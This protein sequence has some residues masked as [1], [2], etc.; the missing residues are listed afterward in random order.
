MSKL[1]LRR[2]PDMCFEPY[3]DSSM[4]FAFVIQLYDA[5]YKGHYEGQTDVID[6]SY[7]KGAIA[8][9]CSLRLNTDIVE[10]KIPVFFLVEDVL[11]SKIL[12]DLLNAGIKR[13]RIRC[14]TVPDSPV[15]KYRVS[16]G[17]YVIVDSVINQYGSYCKWDADLFA[18]CDPDIGQKLSTYWLQGD[19]IGVMEFHYNAVENVDSES[20]AHWF[21]KWDGS[22]DT[23]DYNFDRSRKSAEEAIGIDIL[24]DKGDRFSSMLCGIMRFPCIDK[25]PRDFLDF[26]FRLEPALGDEELILSLWVKYSNSWIRS[27]VPQPMCWWGDSVKDFRARGAY[28]L[29]CNSYLETEEDWESCFRTDIGASDSP[30][31][32]SLKDGGND[33]VP[34]VA[35]L[36]LERRVDRAA[37][38][39]DAL[40]SSGFSGEP[41]RIVG[42][43]RNDYENMELLVED[44][45]GE[46]SEFEVYTVGNIDI[47]DES[48]WLPHQWSY[49][50]CLDWI[51]SQD[52]HVML[53]EDDMVLA[54]SWD[55][56]L[57]LLWELP[58]DYSIAMLN[59]NHDVTAHN[60][61][62]LFNDHWYVGA[63][64]NGTIANVISPDGARRWKDMI[65]ENVDISAEVHMFRNQLPGVY[66]TVSPL[67]LTHPDE[68]DVSDLTPH[69]NALGLSLPVKRV[70]RGRAYLGL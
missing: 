53:L 5:Q 68:I 63:K 18:C 28:F 52:D 70:S 30:P 4:E 14:F 39:V 26:V 24:C 32:L 8:A 29:H 41:H 45:A 51:A 31:V 23:F 13:D 62:P 36:N 16:K 44:A 12:L 2:L 33:I 42:I 66:S 60:S 49:L 3:D 10:R 20:H 19:E 50:R 21:D 34:K 43:D 27:L 48:Y 22:R 25:L 58:C 11:H 59:Y 67:T 35:F 7:I 6:E 17:F 65:L 69:H 46:Y 55:D 9:A 37:G 1:H 15:V 57:G 61:N 56:T 47:T 64:S 54:H 40:A 38:F